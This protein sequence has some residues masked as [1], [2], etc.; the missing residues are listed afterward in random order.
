MKTAVIGIGSNSIRMLQAEIQSGDYKRLGVDREPTRLFAGL[1][2][3]GNLTGESM[4]KT[5]GVVREF[6]ARAR[7]RGCGEVHVFATSASRDAR[8]GSV[9]LEMLRQAAGTEPVIISGEEEGIL[10]FLG[11]TRVVPD[12]PRCGVMDIGGGSTELVIGRG[13][14][15]ERSVSCQ[16]G[17]VR[18]FR[19]FP[20]HSRED[21]AAVESEA[22][23]ILT[24]KLKEEDAG[25]WKPAPSVWVGTGGTFTVLGAMVRGLDWKD[26]TNMHGTRIEREKVREIGRKL[27]DLPLPER[28]KLRGLQ[29]ARADIVVHGIC[30]LLAVMDYLDIAQIIV[31]EC[32][33]LDGYIRK[34]CLS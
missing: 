1:D 23:R 32:G 9:F 30:I 31:S 13:T 28:L 34:Y 25:V 21:M 24:E 16:M 22:R 7:G 4:E 19:K 8:N 17:A 14:D 33:N 20:I 29:P 3:Q 12:A 2:A 18:L 11:A 6:A 10:S 27:A 5:A 26:R 15:I